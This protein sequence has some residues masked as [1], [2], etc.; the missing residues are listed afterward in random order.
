M[1]TKIQQTIA[2]WYLL[3]LSTFAFPWNVPGLHLLQREAQDDNAR[4]GARTV[5][6][7]V[8]ATATIAK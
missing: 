2:V 7:T 8:R 4:G 3:A 1:V 6:V 5:T